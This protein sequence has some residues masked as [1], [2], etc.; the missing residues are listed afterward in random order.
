MKRPQY[1]DTRDAEQRLRKH[2]LDAQ[3]RPE[4]KQVNKFWCWIGL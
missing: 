1:G 2:N 4:A 3:A